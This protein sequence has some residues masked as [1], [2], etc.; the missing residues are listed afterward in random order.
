M[1]FLNTRYYIVKLARDVNAFSQ[2]TSTFSRLICQPGRVCPHG[3]EPKK[4]RI[5]ALEQM[6]DLKWSRAYAGARPNLRWPRNS[7]PRRE[8]LEQDRQCDNEI[9]ERRSRVRSCLLTDNFR[10]REDA[11]SNRDVARTFGQASCAC[12]NPHR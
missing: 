9:I 2:T 1:T 3:F 6:F 5:A 7:A 11:R 4:S 10:K 12:S 8:R